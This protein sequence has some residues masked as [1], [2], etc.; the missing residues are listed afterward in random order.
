MSKFKIGICRNVCCCYEFE[1]ESDS[2]DQAIELAMQ[3][4]YDTIWNGGTVDYEVDYIEE[5]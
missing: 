5:D 3:Q 1:V 4:A 2:E